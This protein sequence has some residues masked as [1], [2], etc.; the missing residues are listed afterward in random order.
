M[1]GGEIQDVLSRVER[2]ENI[3]RKLWKIFIAMKSSLTTHHLKTISL[4]ASFDFS[5]MPLVM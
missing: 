4:N 1:G 2:T 5:L 3:A